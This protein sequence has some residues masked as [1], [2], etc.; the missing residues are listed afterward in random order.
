[1]RPPE[2]YPLRFVI[3]RGRPAH[4]PSLS[5]Q[6]LLESGMARRHWNR[7]RV[8]EAIEHRVARNLLISSRTVR[9]KV[10]SLYAA[11]VRHFGSWATALRAAGHS[12]PPNPSHLWTTDEMIEALTATHRACGNTLAQSLDKR[13][14]R[15][16]SGIFES[17]RYAFGS[18]PA[19]RA[20]AGVAAQHGWT[21][22]KVL[23]GL[24]AVA[25]NGLVQYGSVEAKNPSLVKATTY[26]FGSW[27]AA[28][29][30]A[31]LRPAWRH[32][33]P[34]PSIRWTRET[35]VKLLRQ[36]ARKGPITINPL[37]KKYAGIY[38]AA[39]R[40]FGSWWNARKAAGIPSTL[41]GDTHNQPRG[42]TSKPAILG[43]S[44]RIPA[45]PREER[46]RT[47]SRWPT[48]TQSSSCGSRDGPAVGSP[49]SW[50]STGT[51]SANT[52][53]GSRENQP[54]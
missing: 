16:G 14:Q 51:R 53:R 7:K 36:A 35:V 15:N 20:I 50:D 33:H 45:Q 38:K 8:I 54:M 44:P 49:A 4:L 22:E 21:R 42:I 26:H 9:A 24:R 40:E 29:A 46:W 13:Y 31:G 18:L 27:R 17:I 3:V 19:A 43:T 48:Y 25:K 5:Y 37:R 41:S 23:A 52:F 34:K 47:S 12:P 1:M 39:Q 6:G 30:A 2:I 11:A 10:E 32:N 28:V